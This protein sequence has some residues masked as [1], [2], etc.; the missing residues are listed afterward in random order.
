MIWLKSLMLLLGIGGAHLQ[1]FTPSGNVPALGSNANLSG[2]VDFGLGLYKQLTLERPSENFISSPYSIWAALVVVYF[3]AAGNTQAQL[4]KVLQVADKP[5]ANRLWKG[6]EHLYKQEY[7]T[8]ISVDVANRAYINESFT[9]LP[10]V[11]T[12]FPDELRTL[13]FY[14]TKKAAAVMNDFVSQKTRG[15]IPN[16]VTEDLIRSANVV[17][18]NAIHFRG[19]WKKAFKR[20]STQRRD[21]SVAPSN[22][23][24]VDMMSQVEDFNY[25]ESGELDARVL[26]MPYAGSSLSMILLLPNA[27]GKGSSP[28]ANLVRRLSSAA[29]RDAIS[30]SRLKS[31]PVDVLL[32]KIKFRGE[33][34]KNLVDAIKK[35][36]IKDIFNEIRADLSQFSSKSK[37]VVT[38]II[39]KAHLDI[40]EEGTEPVAAAKRN[41]EANRNRSAPVQFHCDRP[42]A[43]VICDRKTNN[44]LFIGDVKDP[45]SLQS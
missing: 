45:G 21:F 17:L 6:L 34:S 13:N 18:V 41:P 24:S 7:S 14:D 20:P 35:M 28:L 10:C 32:P 29:L 22:T 2:I 30:T 38:D 25:G 5:S 15:F 31:R 16:I 26:E 11:Q 33:L 23:V 37:L 44:I 43:F 1:C 12:A 8:T 3:G 4:A 42:F 27:N 40:D 36:G 39:H 19:L 9:L